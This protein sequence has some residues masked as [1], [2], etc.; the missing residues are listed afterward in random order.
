MRTYIRAIRIAVEKV[1]ATAALFNDLP[2]FLLWLWLVAKP[3]ITFVVANPTC[4]AALVISII[5]IVI[6]VVAV[7][8][9]KPPVL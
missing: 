3:V 9:S 2:P 6:A 1:A 7:K 8:R 4:V 5:A